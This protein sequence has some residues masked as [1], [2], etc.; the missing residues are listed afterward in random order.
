MKSEFKIQFDFAPQ[1]VLIVRFIDLPKSKLL[2][3][4]FGGKLERLPAGWRFDLKG[5]YFSPTK[6]R[7]PIIEIYRDNILRSQ[8]KHWLETEWE[9]FVDKPE[10][11]WKTIIENI[12][13][14]TANV[15]F[16]E[17]CHCLQEALP[18]KAKFEGDLPFR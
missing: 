8:R 7:P 11:V 1:R 10:D 14:K 17:I 15:I 2:R 6:T 13:L 4:V 16:H 12:W 3:E 18:I 9:K 5:Y